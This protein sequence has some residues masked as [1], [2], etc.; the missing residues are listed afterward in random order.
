MA[1]A[2]DFSVMRRLLVPLLTASAMIVTAPAAIARPGISDGGSA[3]QLRY[4]QCFST[5]IARITT[6]AA[7]TENVQAR[8]A[9][10]R[11]ATDVADRACQPKPSTYVVTRAVTIEN[12]RSADVTLSCRSANDRVLSIKRVGEGDSDTE[13]DSTYPRVRYN[14]ENRSG[15][16]KTYY[17]AITCAPAS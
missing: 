8:T 13:E 11:T 10:I 7:R 2:T 14:I 4:S 6:E 15:A 9:K 1:Q 12:D 17:P 3:D 16:T 5:S